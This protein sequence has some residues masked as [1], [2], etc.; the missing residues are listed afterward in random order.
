MQ[1]FRA[2]IF[3]LALSA[4]AISGSLRAQTTDPGLDF[5]V[6]PESGA[7]E[8][9][10]TASEGKVP[11]LRVR[12]QAE[13]GDCQPLTGKERWNL[14]L[15]ETFWSPGAFFR[16]AGP[17]LGTHLNNEPPEWGQGTAGYSRRF[18]NRFGRFALRESYEAAGAA[19]LQHEVRY[20]RGSRSGFLPRAAHALTASF[21]THD[22]NGR[23]VPHISRVGSAFAA[24]FTGNLWMP[25][26]YG[27]TSSALRRV[28]MELGVSSAFNLIREFAPE[29]KRVLPW[30]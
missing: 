24:E 16:A 5:R 22:K 18:A 10:G 28:G 1:S 9:G 30:K 12:A 7:D 3:C 27:D 17:A 8:N 20:R 14:Y 15:R 13:P 2:A 4:L 19:L 26:G 11:Q 6:L 25:A 21:V 29:L 23:R